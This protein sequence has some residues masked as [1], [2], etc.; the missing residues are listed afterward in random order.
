MR[1]L[2]F[3]L[4]VA[5]TCAQP[6]KT[7]TRSGLEPFM[8]STGNT[9]SILVFLDLHRS[10]H[11]NACSDIDWNVFELALILKYTSDQ[12]VVIDNGS[13]CMHNPR[14]SNHI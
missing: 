13:Y 3:C 6:P 5:V 10:Y 8:T 4:L 7:P 1:S 12:Q 9:S 14:T 2:I 11:D